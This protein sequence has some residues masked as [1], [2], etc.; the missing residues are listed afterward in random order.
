MHG[1]SAFVINQHGNEVLV[2]EQVLR[3]MPVWSRRKIKY[4]RSG[5]SKSI[6]LIMDMNGIGDNI[7]AMPAIYQKIKDGFE[8]VI[9]YYLDKEVFSK[10]CFSSLGCRIYYTNYG[11]IKDFDPFTN[12]MQKEKFGAVYD[13][14]AWATE[15]DFFGDGTKS[16]FQVF[17]DLIETTLPDEFS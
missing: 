13:L 7:Q 1:T 12:L 5:N 8:V 3:D 9:F 15:D 6:G 14:R 2:S 17:A 16:R 4:E 10:D 11:S